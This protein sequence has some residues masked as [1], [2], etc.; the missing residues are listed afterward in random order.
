MS[1]RMVSF[2]LLFVTA[3]AAAGAQEIQC[4]PPDLSSAQKLNP[5]LTKQ[6]AQTA[7]LP[8][9]VA[10]VEAA[11]D[12]YQANRGSG[13]DALPPLTSAAL[14]FKTT[15]GTVGGLTL[16]LF[17]FKL[18]ASH[19]KDT[20]NDLTLNY[21]VK[22]SPPRG[23]KNKAPQSLSDSLANG[24]LAAA[25]AV[26]ASPTVAGLPISRSQSTCSSASRMTAM[27]P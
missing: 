7:D 12:C 19:E 15:T 5:S 2:I 22:T 16:S 10:S 23:N 11:I 3:A 27:P 1:H 6:P 4:K 13:P 26:K 9:V 20:I 18:G 25:A 24:I 14:E 21:G 8:S 17:I